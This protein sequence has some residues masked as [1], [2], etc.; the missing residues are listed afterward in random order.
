M[1][2]KEKEMIWIERK[3]CKIPIC[4]QCMNHKQGGTEFYDCKNTFGK[5]EYEPGKFCA[6]GQCCCYSIEHGRRGE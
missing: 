3:G 6:R 5:L 4:P 1:H 2:Y